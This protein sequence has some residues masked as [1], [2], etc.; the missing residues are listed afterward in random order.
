MANEP[1]ST[2]PDRPSDQGRSKLRRLAFP[3]TLVG[4]A[5]AAVYAF[6]RANSG[7]GQARTH[8]NAKHRDDDTKAEDEAG[9]RDREQVADSAA[10]S[11]RRDP[12]ELE[13]ARRERKARR[14]DRR[15]RM[16]E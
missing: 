11:P 14:E 10:A 16:R 9:E 8:G 4:A 7:D 5:G 6:A 15:R 13:A 3:L 2:A 1:E 12:R